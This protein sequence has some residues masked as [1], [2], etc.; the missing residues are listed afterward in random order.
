MRQR[1]AWSLSNV[2]SS[3]CE[4]DAEVAEAPA[5]ALQCLAASTCATVRKRRSDAFH[6]VGSDCWNLVFAF[7]G[8][9]CPNIVTDG[10]KLRLLHSL[11]QEPQHRDGRKH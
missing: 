3:L 1:A 9:K 10:F 5:V 7:S 4:Y 6:G 11:G 2:I 8:E